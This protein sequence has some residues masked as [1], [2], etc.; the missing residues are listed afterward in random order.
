MDDEDTRDS[1]KVCQTECLRAT[2]G[3]RSDNLLAST[4]FTQ[5]QA[6]MAS[7]FAHQL[8]AVSDTSK[9]FSVDSLPLARIKRIMKQDAADPHP[10]M[11]SVDTIPLMA[12]TVQL[13]IGLLTDLAWR[14]STRP[15]GR[16]TLQVKDI[17]AAA[18]CSKHFDFL[19]DTIDTFDDRTNDE[20]LN[21][22]KGGPPMNDGSMH[23]NELPSML[24]DIYRAHGALNTT[25]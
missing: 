23:S 15:N 17:K 1:R 20:M 13:F 24:E 12:Y 4:L 10:R 5:I 22:S 8:V 19:I 11:I 21:G 25:N 2:R 3:Y 9:P 16:N 7:F 18:R 14:L 6:L